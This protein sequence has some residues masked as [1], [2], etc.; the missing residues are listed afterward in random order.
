MTGT[1]ELCDAR[2]FGVVMAMVAVGEG[3][4][5]V[6]GT[7]WPEVKVITEVLSCPLVEKM[8]VEV[9]GVERVVDVAMVVN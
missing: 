9:T 5:R 3:T 6:V 8:L 7:T 4:T 1:F 2:D